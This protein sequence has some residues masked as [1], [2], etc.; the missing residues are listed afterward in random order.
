MPAARWITPAELE[1]RRDEWL[2]L[3]EGCEFPSVF[4]DPRWVC[5]WWRHYGGE[6]E[7]WLLAVEDG[8]RS[9]RG[10]ALLVREPARRART[11]TFAATR[12]NGL[13]TLLC[14]PG[15]ELEV[16]QAVLDALAE[17]RSE[18]DLW[19]IARLP[20]ASAL[21][22]LLLG[23]EAP[24][25]ALAHDVLLQPYVEL[26]PEVEQ[27][28]ARYG[29]KRRTDH[30]RKWRRLLDAGAQVRLVE[31]PA[32]VSSFVGELVEL[33][34]ER[35]SAAGQSHAHMDER[36]ERFT[37]DVARALLP[38][39]ARMWALELEGKLLTAKLN[40]VEAWR[41]HGFITAVSDE[42]LG[43]SPGHALE[44]QTIHAMIR[45]GR[46]EFDL[47][48]GRDGYKYQWHAVDREVLRVIVASPTA[49]GRVAGIPA[50]ADLRLRRS[51]GAEALR[52]R[53]G[54]VPERATAEHPAKLPGEQG[55]TPA[56]GE[57]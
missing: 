29:G 13:E 56:A 8:D 23:G 48:P 10:L 57:R 43:L 3:T 5:A 12:W 55:T 21:A 15:A 41:E 45:D 49:R 6:E 2:A 25:R 47:G 54:V 18:W 11:L 33:R 4:G 35:A 40:F 20:R 14:A 53:R 36:F 39:G 27:F 22:G 37:A 1:G 24:L 34:R 50:G 30:R 52:R 26:P 16:A 31:D 38:S 7:P 46:R 44:R 51:A 9:L 19:R 17:R 32:E 42:Q 28:E